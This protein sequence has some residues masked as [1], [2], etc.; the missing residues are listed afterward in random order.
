VLLL[1]T[2]CHYSRLVVEKSQVFNKGI[3]GIMEEKIVYT[4]DEAAEI[5]KISR[6]SAYQGIERNEIPHI[7]IGRRILVPRV[8]LERLLN[9]ATPVKVS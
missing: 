6:P 8:A 4:V 7:R 1:T 3:G 2:I 9:E 5:L